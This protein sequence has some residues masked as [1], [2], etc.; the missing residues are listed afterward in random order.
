MI[1]V[2]VVGVGVVNEDP[3]R[4]LMH[5]LASVERLNLRWSPSEKWNGVSAK[6]RKVL[7]T[8]DLMAIEAA[9]YAMQ[10]AGLEVAPSAPADL[11]CI[12]F[13]T[14][15]G[16]RAQ[17]CRQPRMRYRTPDQRPDVAALIAAVKRGEV[18]VDPF[19]LLHDMDNTTL[20]W[21]CKR[22][23]ISSLN[24]QLCQPHAP[25]YYALLEAIE[26]IADGECSVCLVG[27]YQTCDTSAVHVH[28]A[29]GIA[30]PEDSDSLAGGAAFVVL[31]RAEPGGRSYGR[32]L[33]CPDEAARPARPEVA[34]GAPALQPVLELISAA[35]RVHAGESCVLVDRD[36]PAAPPLTFIPE[37]Q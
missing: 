6:D 7:T 11:G 15:K 35:L 24:L 1:G 31:R 27:G 17:E 2:S 12:V 25:G 22:Y 20:W 37:A 5:E 28:H 23:A 3:R 30:L 19:M 4:E 36:A 16:S 18:V 29:H 10:D 8:G 33:V 26:C 13:N 21:L 32:L 9:S 34:F 14:G